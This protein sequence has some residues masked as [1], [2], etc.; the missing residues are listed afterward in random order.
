MHTQLSGWP[1]YPAQGGRPTQDCALEMTGTVCTKGW[2]GVFLKHSSAV[3]KS[4]WPFTHAFTE[5]C[6]A[7]VPD[8]MGQIMQT[9]S[10]LSWSFVLVGQRQRDSK[11]EGIWRSL[12]YLVGMGSGS[13]VHI[14]P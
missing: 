10:L 11:A 14:L 1:R 9:W 5:A 8:H 3:E 4:L 6:A 12:N 7:P 13:R 2:L